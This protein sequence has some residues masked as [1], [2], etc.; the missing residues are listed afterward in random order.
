MGQEQSTPSQ[1][2][3]SD[4]YSSYISQQQ[5]LIQLQQQQINNLYKMNLDQSSNQM[6]VPTNIAFQQQQQQQQQQHQQLPNLDLPTLPSTKINPYKVL[7][8]PKQYDMSMLKKAYLKR[9]MKAHPDRGGSKDEFQQI[10]I[11]YALLKK[12]LKEE[13][14]IHHHHELRGNAK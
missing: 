13:G 14:E 1:P 7:G 10:S 5:R 8:I 4:V 2:N 9:A 12:K 11:A 6:K 3:V